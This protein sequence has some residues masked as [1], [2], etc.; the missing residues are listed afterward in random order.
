MIL[1]DSSVWID[2]LRRRDEILVDLLDR[3]QVLV[4]PF[5]I[6]ELAMGSLG[7]REAVL[8]DLLDLKRAVVADDDGVMHFVEANNLFGQGLGYLDAHL[9][10]STKLTAETSLWTRDKRLAAAAERLSI[11][12]RV[13]H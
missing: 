9:L 10:A 8:Q 5:V 7:H 12:A 4:H 3:E 2:H 11:A 6:G 13:T 1:V